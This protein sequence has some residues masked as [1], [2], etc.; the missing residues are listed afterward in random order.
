MKY[1]IYLAH[2][3]LAKKS[4]LKANSHVS[5][6][7]EKPQGSDGFRLGVEWWVLVVIF[8]GL[9]L[10]FLLAYAFSYNRQHSQPKG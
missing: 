1:L 8:L 4:S 9:I 10:F 7:N 3:A 6:S 2:I 5:G